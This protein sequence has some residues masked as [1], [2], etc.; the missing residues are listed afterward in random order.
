MSSTRNR[1]GRWPDDPVTSSETG[2]TASGA[3]SAD[4]ACATRASIESA[5]R[6]AAG[7]RVWRRAIVRRVL[8]EPERGALA[9]EHEWF[10][11]G[12]SA[13]NLAPPAGEEAVL[14]G[15]LDLHQVVL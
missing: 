12:P 6:R 4:H 3:T 14:A 1:D 11:G 10:A 7:A 2:S 13:R 9:L 15:A 5:G 8:G